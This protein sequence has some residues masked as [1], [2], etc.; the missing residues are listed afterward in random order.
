MFCAAAR[1]TSNRGTAAVRPASTTILSS[2]SSILV[3][4]WCCPPSQ[5]DSH[6]AFPVSIPT[7]ILPKKG[8]EEAKASCRSGVS[9]ERAGASEIANG[10]MA[11]SAFIEAIEP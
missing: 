6:P 9:N 3:S 11:T 8:R 7:P 2:E 10:A 4:G 1:G 5:E